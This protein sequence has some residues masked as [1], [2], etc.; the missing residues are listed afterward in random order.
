MASGT[1][2]RLRADSGRVPQIIKGLGKKN[3]T[4]NGVG[5][6][7]RIADKSGKRLGGRGCG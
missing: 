5:D 6:E 3:R 2:S 7:G 4:V 1:R